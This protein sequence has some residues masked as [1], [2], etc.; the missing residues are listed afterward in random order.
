MHIT[1]EKV[2]EITEMSQSEVRMIS[3]IFG[4]HKEDVDDISFATL[5]IILVWDFF[6]RS[7]M[8]LESFSAALPP[9]TA[10]MQ[11]YADEFETAM[12][13]YMTV[14][15][16]HIPKCFITL[17]DNR[18][19][20]MYTDSQHPIKLWDMAEDKWAGVLVDYK[21][22]FTLTMSVPMLYFKTAAR[23]FGHETVAEACKHT[24]LWA[25]KGPDAPTT[26]SE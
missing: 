11:T 4:L 10:I 20:G 19:I 16:T 1:T 21:P 9:F 5:L 25:E 15:K 14:H 17:I 2:L 22:V 23:H 13:G 7:G 3:R 26:K 12:T 8:A 6:K 18:F 24:P